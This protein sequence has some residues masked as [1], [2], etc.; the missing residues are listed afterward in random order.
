MRNHFV[1]CKTSYKRE[2]LCKDRSTYRNNLPPSPVDLF[3]EWEVREDV[4]IS[5]S[6]YAGFHLQRLK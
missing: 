6:A 3:T 5:K 1:P 2:N 4:G